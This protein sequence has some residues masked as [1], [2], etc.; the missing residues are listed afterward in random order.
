M[1]QL[2]AAF[3]I[4]VPMLETTVA[5][6]RTVKARKRNGLRL[7]PLPDRWTGSAFTGIAIIS[8]VGVFPTILQP[9]CCQADNLSNVTC[10]DFTARI[11]CTEFDVETGYG[12]VHCW[13]VLVV[14]TLGDGPKRFNELRKGLGSISQRMLTLSLRV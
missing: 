7:D 12:L 9:C 6:H 3:C 10:T 2:A 11:C 5:I 1:S 14:W 13:K 4:Q 8:P